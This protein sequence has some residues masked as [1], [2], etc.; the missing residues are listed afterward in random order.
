M[1]R[2]SDGKGLLKV[3]GIRQT[4]R[5]QYLKL[6]ASKKLRMAFAR[7]LFSETI[8]TTELLKPCYYY[9]KH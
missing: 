5:E 4:A 2:E 6:Q 1:D 3:A 8:N 7:K 9:V